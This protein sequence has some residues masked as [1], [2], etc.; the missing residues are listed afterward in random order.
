MLGEFTIHAGD[1]RKD[2]GGQ[3]LTDTFVLHT[4]TSGWL[5]E[6]IKAAEI[7]SLE[8]AD[9]ETA[10]SFVGAAGM[11]AL[12]TLLLGPVGLLAGALAGGSKKKV[13]F[14]CRFRDGR[15]F[16]GTADSKL[17]TK[18]QAAIFDRPCAPPAPPAAAEQPDMFVVCPHCGVGAKIAA[19]YA[20]HEAQCGKCNK[21]FRV[22]IRL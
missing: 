10:K 6:K 2:K 15:K 14:V 7:D 16:L 17:W 22:P 13:T 1:F 5:G 4:K 19:R 3:F 20:G 18:M 9:E 8:M 11:A 12:G 21:T